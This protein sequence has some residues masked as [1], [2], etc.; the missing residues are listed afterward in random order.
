MS[1]LAFLAKDARL[2]LRN[3]PLLAA[4]I[5]YP[6]LLALVL[7]AA[8]QEPP[9]TL[10]LAVVDEDGSGQTVDV[11]GTPLGVAD[12][13]AAAEPFA[14]VTQVRDEGSALKMLRQQRVDA[15]LIIPQGFMGDLAR[16]GSTAT[17]RLVV[18]ESDPVRAGVARSAIEGAVD[19]FVEQ[20][21]QK[22]IDDVVRLLQLT[23]EGGTTRVLVV[24]V[25][26][27]GIDASIVR[28]HEVRATLPPES[29]EARKLQEV[30][31][32]LGF[33]RNL[34]GDSERFLVSTAIPLEVRAEGLSTEQASIASVALPG[35]LVL[36]VFWTGSLAA[37]LLAARERET[38]VHRRLAAAPHAR[39]LP[40]LSKS[41]VALVAALV[42]AGI[43]LALAMTLLSA[44]VAD[45]LMTTLALALAALAAAALGALAA[46][47]ARTTGGAALLAVLA[48]MPMLLL[49]GLFYP[50]AYMPEDAR[51]VASL[52]PVTL[53]TEALRGAML[54]A[55]PLVELALPLAGLAASALALGAGTWALGR[56]A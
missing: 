28:L 31:D 34:L 20:I 4:L 2:V 11:G 39:V 23:V 8:F 43:V 38:G 51:A 30:I 27:L 41:I 7:G 25:H 35:A 33:A 3:R 15:V 12:L 40:L 52:L 46:A 24:D 44:Q 5:L 47:I 18:D 50:L 32:F 17:L 55:S 56:R 36:G 10:D 22:K 14:D 54:R 37:A 13:L 1:F 16:L 9:Q 42:P 26:V 29:T 48:L 45:P 6:F 49:G 21:V 53:A 19:A